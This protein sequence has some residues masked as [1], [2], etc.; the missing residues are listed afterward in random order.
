MMKSRPT[1]VKEL[2]QA[3]KAA[4]QGLVDASKWGVGGVWFGG[5]QQ[6]KHFVWFFKWPEDVRNELCT[7]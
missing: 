4:Y 5:T 7:D 6:L 2:V 3:K 1:N